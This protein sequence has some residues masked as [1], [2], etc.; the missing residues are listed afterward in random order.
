TPV[1]F[2]NE[3]MG[4][5]E[6]INPIQRAMNRR[7][8]GAQ[9]AVDYNEQP[10]T[11]WNENAISEEDTAHLNKPGANIQGNLN[12][13]LG[14]PFWRFPPAELPRGSIEL[15]DRMQQWMQLLGSQPFGSEGMPVTTDASGELQR[16]VRFDTDRVWGATIRLHSYG[17]ARVAD[18]I[19][20]ILAACM[21][22]DRLLVLSGEDQA[23]EFLQVSRD[24]F[25]GRVHA[26]PHPESQVLESRQ[27][28]QNRV[29]ALVGAQMLP[30]Q[31][32]LEV[33]NYPDVN[34][35]LRPGGPAYSMAVR[36]NLELQLG[37]L[38]PVFP[39]HDHATHLLVH[40]RYMQTPAFRD[41]DPAMQQMFRM[42]VFLHEQLQVAE[43][44]RMGA[45]AAAAM[46]PSLGGEAGGEE[47]VPGGE[48]GAPK[49]EDLARGATAPGAADPRRSSIALM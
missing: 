45:M 19:G 39:E 16:E 23:A 12:P 5:L 3:G 34:R 41:G 4:D 33:L 8:A 24:M 29:L 32:G 18:K 31:M 10:L 2:R 48:E 40:K 13:A 28:K 22:D 27:E 20:H 37:A 11:V 9:D 25:K 35:A 42:H 44:Q 38:S 15:A 17:W 30:P 7:M 47:A 49:G 26:Y 36:E 43:M 46:P 6:I 1:P 14:P 21:D